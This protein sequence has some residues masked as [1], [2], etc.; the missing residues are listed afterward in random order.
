MTTD[1]RPKRAFVT[2]TTADGQTYHIAGIAKGAGMIAP[3]MA[4]ML[5]FIVTDAALDPQQVRRYCCSRRDR[6]TFNQIVVD[7]DTSTNDSVFLLAN[8]ASGVTI[9]DGRIAS[10]SRLR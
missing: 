7:G 9:D 3:N 1:T 6:Q 4:T 2:V 10:S 8:G 5:G